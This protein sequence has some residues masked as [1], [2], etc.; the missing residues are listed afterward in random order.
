M[1]ALLVLLLLGKSKINDLEQG[2]LDDLAMDVT[3]PHEDPELFSA[4]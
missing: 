4:F 1:S 2:S 3:S